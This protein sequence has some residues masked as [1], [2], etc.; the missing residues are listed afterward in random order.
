[1]D[2]GIFLDIRKCY[3]VVR[4]RTASSSRIIFDEFAI[5]CILQR[6]KSLTASKL[7]A[8]QGI[9]C[10]TMTHRGNRLCDLGYMTRQSCA[11]DRRKLKCTITRRGNTFVNKTLQA[12]I[13]LAP[14]ES[15]LAGYDSA[16]LADAVIRSAS[17]PMAADS[18]VM[19]CFAHLEYA[20]MTVMHIVEVTGMLQP[21]VSMALMRLETD[22][23]VDRGKGASGATATRKES[24]CVLTKAGIAASKQ[25]LET[26]QEL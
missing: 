20:P 5:L 7:A 17:V 25:I 3:S 12:I 11:E 2:Q 24:G 1:M 18:L 22:G 19:L 15:E 21:T 13:D 16:R 4:Q 14:A 8:L 26:V 10:P 9:S 23:L 6:D